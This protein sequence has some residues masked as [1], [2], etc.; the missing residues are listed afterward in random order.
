MDCFSFVQNEKEDELSLKIKDVS[1][2]NHFL[3]NSKIIA[4]DGENVTGVDFITKRREVNFSRISDSISLINKSLDKDLSSDVIEPITIVGVLDFASS[5][6]G[7]DE[8][9]EVT[10]EKNKTFKIKINEGLDDYVRSF[11]KTKVVIEGNSDGNYVY[12][13]SMKESE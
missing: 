7:K 2:Y 13:S 3:S 10:D 9:A 4:P 8:F 12:M 6:P 11:Y 1:Y 5:K